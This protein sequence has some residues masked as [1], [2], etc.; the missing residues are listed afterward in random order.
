MTSVKVLTGNLWA[1]AFFWNH[2]LWLNIDSLAL[3]QIYLPRKI[4]GTY[5]CLYL[6]KIPKYLLSLGIET[7]IRC[8]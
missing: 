7:K 4:G 5:I 1:E 6:N 2:T 3:I 8:I